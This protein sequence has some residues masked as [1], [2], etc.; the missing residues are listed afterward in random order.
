MRRDVR[1]MSGFDDLTS[2]ALVHFVFIRTDSI[3]ENTRK[4]HNAMRFETIYLILR[5]P[6]IDVVSRTLNLDNGNLPD[7]PLPFFL[8]KDRI[9]SVIVA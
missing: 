1:G 9:L 8:F 7:L 4:T 3:H 5:F 2:L 6:R